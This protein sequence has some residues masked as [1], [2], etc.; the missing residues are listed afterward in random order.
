[1]VWRLRLHDHQDAA[2]A[3]QKTGFTYGNLSPCKGIVSAGRAL[4]RQPTGQQEWMQ[5]G[6]DDVHDRTF[7]KMQTHRPMLN[8][9]HNSCCMESPWV[10][11]WQTSQY[12]LQKAGA[13]FR[14]ANEAIVCHS[15]GEHVALW[16]RSVPVFERLQLRALLVIFLCWTP[17]WLIVDTS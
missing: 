15:N 5:P 9:K 11:S 1:M 7:H 8:S 3:E 4:R 12:K 16:H 6:P 10:R 13:Q 14:Q 2:H 17:I